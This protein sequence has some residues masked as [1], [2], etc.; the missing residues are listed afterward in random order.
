MLDTGASMCFRSSHPEVFL[1][2]GV[3]KIW[4]K[5]TGEHP[6]QG[7]ISIKLQSNFTETTLRH[8]CYPVNLLHIFRAPFRKNTSGRLLLVFLSIL[9]SAW[10][11]II[12]N[13]KNHSE[14]KSKMQNEFPRNEMFT[15]SQVGLILEHW[16]IKVHRNKVTEIKCQ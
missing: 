7:A 9:W 12:R 14:D 5:F 4:S 3:L 13:F 10:Q 6:C 2:K 1:G 16:W 11:N 15:P 8:E